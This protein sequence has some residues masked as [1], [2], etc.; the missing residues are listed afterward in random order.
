MDHTSRLTLPFIMPSQAQKHITHNEAL[1]ALD[2]LV[3]PVVQ[4]L[5]LTT[6]PSLPLEGEAHVVAV[7]ATGVWAGHA[8]EIA[9]FQSG[10]WRFFEPAPGWQVYCRA[11]RTQY[12][13]DGAAWVPLAGEAALAPIIAALQDLSALVLRS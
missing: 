4:S 10:A 11:D 2:V 12:V 13:F 3:Q 5:D 9:A 1:Q 6:V 8:L 7:G